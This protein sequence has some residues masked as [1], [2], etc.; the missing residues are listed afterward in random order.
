LEKTG[1]VVSKRCQN[2]TWPWRCLSAPE[3]GDVSKNSDVLQLME[4]VVLCAI[5]EMVGY[6]KPLKY[7]TLI[8]TYMFNSNSFLKR[9]WLRKGF[10]A[11]S[12]RSKGI[13]ISPCLNSKN[14][15]WSTAAS[16]SPTIT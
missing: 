16:N 7:I 13:D 8:R 15:S 4:L 2:V 14:S 12:S 11:G 9:G 1:F 6:V 3:E 5:D 10:Q